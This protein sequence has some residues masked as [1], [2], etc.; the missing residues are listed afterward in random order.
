MHRFIQ[1]LRQKPKATRR[2]IAFG[3]SLSVTGVI[4]AIW[5][6]VMI[7]GPAVPAAGQQTQTASPL[8]AFQ[9]NAGSA[10]SELQQQFADEPGGTSTPSDPTKTNTATDGT[11]AGVGET[12][13]VDTQPYWQVNDNK[14]G[15]TNQ[16]E[17]SVNE[18]GGESAN[19]PN[20][21]PR[22]PTENSAD[23]WSQDKDTESDDWF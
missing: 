13:T 7:Q 8:G 4:F 3:T 21:D 2:R 19:S 16:E 9:D 6:T 11:D 1:K 20:A 10:F 17:G 23:F 15:G 12:R 5:L 22:T 14:E 18:S